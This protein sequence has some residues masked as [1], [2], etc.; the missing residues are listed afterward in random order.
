MSTAQ[1]LAF[2]QFP[3]RVDLH[4][5]MPR[6]GEIYLSFSVNDDRRGGMS[7]RTRRKQERPSQHDENSHDSSVKVVDPGV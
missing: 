4:D 7:E 2:A 1:E 3:V 6:V 5:A